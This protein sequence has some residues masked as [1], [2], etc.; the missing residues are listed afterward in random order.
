MDYVGSFVVGG[1][2]GALGQILIM[3]LPSMGVPGDIVVLVM[4]AILAVLGMLLDI[5]GVW[6]KLSKVGGTG[7]MLPFIGLPPAMGGG[8][9]AELDSGKAMGSGIFDGIKGILVVFGLGAAFCFVVAL[10]MKL[11]G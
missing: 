10:I 6:A 7:T 9:K 1:A 2:V 11:V 4:L 3:V 5:F 8:V